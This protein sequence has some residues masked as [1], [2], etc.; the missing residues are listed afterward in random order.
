M[1]TVKPDA[2]RKRGAKIAGDLGIEATAAVFEIRCYQVQ[3]L[4][5]ADEARD[6]YAKRVDEAAAEILA[7]GDEEAREDILWAMLPDHI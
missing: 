2:V 4:L 7:T 1:P 5:S 3:G 6:F